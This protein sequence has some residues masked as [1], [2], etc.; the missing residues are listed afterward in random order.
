MKLT[1]MFLL[2]LFTAAGLFSSCE[3]EEPQAAKVTF[4][5]IAAGDIDG[6]VT[7]SGG[8]TSK[9]YTWENSLSKADY[10]MDI[11][12]TKGGSFR[13]LVK[14]ANGQAVLDKTLVAGAGEDSKSGVTSSGTPGSW[15]VSVTL[16]D[17]NGDGSFSLSKGD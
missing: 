14:D 3:K 6:D 11:T 1:K 10:N 17:F 5:T 16:T 8:S 12:A 9:N 13:L 7:G 15:T 2:L 4:A